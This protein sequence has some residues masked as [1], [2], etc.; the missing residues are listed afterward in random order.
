MAAQLQALGASGKRALLLYPPGLDYI[1]AFFGCLYAGAIAV[2]AYPPRNQRHAARLQTAVSVATDSQA[3][4]ALTTTAI[5]PQLQSLLA[6][7]RGTIAVLK[8]VRYGGE[9]Y[10]Y[11]LCPMPYSL[12]PMPARARHVTEKGYI[13]WLTTDT[14]PPELKTLGKNPKLTQKP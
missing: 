9:S 14:T 8:K 10:A 12:C 2:P 13:H 4:I 11:A 6:D 3:A 1:A 5:L 7:K